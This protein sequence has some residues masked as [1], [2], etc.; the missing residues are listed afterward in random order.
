[1]STNGH[2]DKNAQHRYGELRIRYKTDHVKVHLLKSSSCLNFISASPRVMSGDNGRAT[3][4]MFSVNSL[5]SELS[6]TNVFII[7]ASLFPPAT[8]RLWQ[9]ALI[10]AS[11]PIHR[12]NDRAAGTL[13]KG[14]KS[15]VPFP[16]EDIMVYLV[17][18]GTYKQTAPQNWEMF[19][20]GAIYRR[21]TL[22][23]R[24]E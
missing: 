24:H 14:T 22:E 16:L 15:N 19:G 7:C 1:M 3:L 21:K 11:P 17:I 9:Y 4:T 2:Y 10:S 6:I 13:R 18:P 20:L 12:R 8:A 5:V 23:K